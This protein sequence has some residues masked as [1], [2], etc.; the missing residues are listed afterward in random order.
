MSSRAKSVVIATLTTAAALL[1]FP[2][3]FALAFELFGNPVHSPTAGWLGP[4]PRSSGECVVDAGK[5]NS[6]QCQDT[7][8][9]SDHRTGCRIW[10][11]LFGYGGT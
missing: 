9:F 10:L 3:R 11:G 2:V 4:T 6:W 7:S 5:V 8:V 1:F